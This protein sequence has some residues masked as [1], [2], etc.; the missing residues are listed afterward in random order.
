MRHADMPVA[1]I[2]G[3]RTRPGRQLLCVDWHVPMADLLITNSFRCLLA[4]RTPANA[5][6]SADGISGQ[7]FDARLAARPM[8]QVSVLADSACPRSRP[9]PG[10]RCWERST[11]EPAMPVRAR[12]LPFIK[13]SLPW[14]HIGH[15][16]AFGCSPDAWPVRVQLPLKVAAEHHCHGGARPRRALPS[17]GCARWTS[18]RP[19]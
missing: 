18:T 10:S 2:S 5:C 3:K 7:P 1:M 15:C 19:T 16:R 14:P 13:P 12:T 8:V 11:G 17:Q 4:S 6:A 9:S